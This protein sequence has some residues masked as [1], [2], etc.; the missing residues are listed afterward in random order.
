MPGGPV[1]DVGETLTDPQVLHREMVVHLDGYT[2]VG[3]P[4]KL[5]RTPGTVRVPPRERGAD[6]AEV[7]DKIGLIDRDPEG[8]QR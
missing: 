5:S 8:E 6:T 2:G 3:I 4:V 1:H 7:L